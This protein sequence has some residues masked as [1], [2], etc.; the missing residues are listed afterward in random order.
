MSPADTRLEQL[1]QLLTAT[2]AVVLSGKSTLTSPHSGDLFDNFDR[3]AI[4]R[5]TIAEV[6]RQLNLSHEHVR[7][8][9]YGNRVSLRVKEALSAELEKRLGGIEP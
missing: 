1:G 7:Q 2:M 6:A 3:V 4:V 5:G 9:A 8:V